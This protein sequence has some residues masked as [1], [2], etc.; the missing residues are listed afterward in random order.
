MLQGIFLVFS[1]AM[2]FF[3]LVADLLY[4]YLDPRVRCVNAAAAP[5]RAGSPGLRR[6]RALASVWREYR[7][8]RPGMIGLAIL[9]AAC[10][11]AGRP[12]PGRRGGPEGD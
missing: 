9:L 1:A 7:G 8:H 6:R 11:G 4:G 2:I 3:N 10:D 12:A 5:R